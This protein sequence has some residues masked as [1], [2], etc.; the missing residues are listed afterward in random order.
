MLAAFSNNPRVHLKR[1]EWPG[2]SDNREGQSGPS[3]AGFV[4]GRCR[5]RTSDLL[6]FSSDAVVYPFPEWVEQSEYQGNDGV[7]KLTAVWTDNFDDF[8][9]EVEEVRDLGDRVMILGGTVG[10]IK[11]TGVPIRQ[12]VGAV[13]SDFRDGKIGEAH[14][15]MAKQRTLEAAGLR[16]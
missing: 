13:F 11:G 15:F 9:T 5:A 7:R 3:E 8:A 16:E 4:S 6:L 12:P 10:R 14:F 1:I 2:S